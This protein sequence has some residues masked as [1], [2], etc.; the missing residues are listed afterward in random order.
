MTWKKFTYKKKNCLWNLGK[1]DLKC[2]GSIL[3]LES[4]SCSVVSD[5]FVTPWTVAHQA[6][7]SMG[8]SR[9]DYWSG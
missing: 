9:Q 3:P 7:L 4:V 5:S 8:F 6:P 2:G 1:E